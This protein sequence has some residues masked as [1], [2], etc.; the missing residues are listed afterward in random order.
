MSKRVILLACLVF[1]VSSCATIISGT[2]ATIT[3]TSPDARRVDLTV[4]DAYYG[5]VQLPMQVDIKRG[6]NASLIIA[7][8][9]NQEGMAK[10]SKTFNPIGLLNI[11]LGGIP[12][13]IVDCATGAITKPEMDSYII[14]LDHYIQPTDQVI[15]PYRP[16]ESSLL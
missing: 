10:V 13:L 12:G 6:F 14:Y 1:I 4:D 8:T 15:I 16:D 2:R 5:N 11:L 7:R 9:H 3:V